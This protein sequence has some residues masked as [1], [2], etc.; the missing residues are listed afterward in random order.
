MISKSQSLSLLSLVDAQQQFV[1]VSEETLL[2]E[3]IAQ[4]SKINHRFVAIDNSTSPKI[5]TPSCSS[6]ILITNN[7]GQL[8][9]IITE[10]DIVRL[11]AEK[12]QLENLTVAQVMTQNIITCKI[13]ELVKPL[14]LIQVMYRNHIRHLPVV[15]ELY[16]PI[17]IVTRG[18]LMGILTQ[19][20]I[21]QAVNVGELQQV[22]QDLQLQVETLQAENVRLLERVNQELKQQVDKQADREKLLLNIA[23]KIRSSLDLQTILQTTVEEVRQHLQ[24]NRVVI[25][26]FEPNW[27]GKVV[28]ESVEQPQWSILNQV[29]RDECFEQTWLT[30]Y[31]EYKSK[32]IAD[33]YQANLSECHIQFLESLHIRANLVIPILVNQKLWGLLIAHHCVEPRLWLTDEI[34]FLEQLGVHLAIA[35][36]QANLLQQAQHTQAELEIEVQ[37]RTNQL[38]QELIERQQAETKVLERQEILRSFYDSSPM[39]MGVVE[40][41]DNDILHLSDNQ[42]TA[43]FFGTTTEALAN[44]KA[45]D[46]GVPEPALQKWLTHY[47]QSQKLGKSVRFEYQHITP[48]KNYWLLAIVSY[49]GIAESGRPRFSYIVE[50]ITDYKQIQAGYNRFSYLLDSSFNEIY[51]FDPETLKFDYVNQGALNNLGYSLEEMQQK[52]AA[53]IKPEITIDQFKEIIYPLVSKQ[54]DKII[55]QSVHR[56]ANGTQYPIEVHLQLSEYLGKQVFLAIIIDITERKEAEAALKESEERYR[57]IVETTQEGIWMLDTD[58]NTSFVNSKMAEMLGYKVEEMLGKSLLTFIEE[59]RHAETLQKLEQRKQGIA[60]QH[61]W[62]FLRKDGTELWALLS[63]NAITNNAGNHIGSLAMVTDISDRQQAE[64]AL[65]IAQ[66]RFSGILDIAN[67]AIIS[68][69]SQQRIILFNQG[70]EKTFG[71]TAEEMIGQPLGKLLPDRFASAHNNHVNSFAGSNGKARRMG[72]RGEIWG[73]RNNGEEFPA[74]ASISKLT[75]GGETIFTTILRDISQRKRDEVALSQLAAIVNSSHD[76]IISKNLDGIITSWNAAA[77]EMFGYTAS[78]IIGCH[79]SQIIP[80]DSRPEADNI[81]ARIREGESVP[82]YETIRQRRDGSLINLALTVSPIRDQKG[83]V[84][85]ASKIARDISERKQAELALKESEERY[86]VLVCH[87]PVGI[88]QTD[89]QGKCLYVNPR[90]MEMTGLSL[91]EALGD[92]WVRSLHP[93]EQLKIFSEWEKTAK[94]KRLFQLEYRFLKPSG[95]EVWVSGQAIAVRDET[96]QVKGYFGTVM[97]ITARK[98]AEEQLRQSQTNLAEAQRIAHLGSWQLDL[99]TGKRTWSDETF[100]IFGLE[101]QSIALTQEVLS[102]L[103]HPDDRWQ[104]QDWIQQVI[105]KKVPVVGE[106]RIIRPDGTMRH[107]ETRAEVILD[108]EG[109]AIKLTGSILDI[110]ERKQAEATKQALFDALPDFM[111]RMRRDGMQLEVLNKDAIHIIKPEENI[112]NIY[113]TD[114]MPLP[115]AQERIAL[116]QQALATNQVQSQEYHFKLNGKTIYEEA[117]IAP[118]GNDEVLVL[119]RDI[120]ERYQAEQA[121]RESEEKFRQLAENIHQ[122]FFILSAEGEMLYISPVYEQVWQRSCE[123]LY[124][125]PRSWLESVHPDDRPVMANALKHQI[126][127]GVSFNETYRI[128]RPDGSIRWVTARS[129]PLRDCTGKVLRFT[130]IAEDVTQQ[131]ESAKAME[132]QLR[133]T[134]LLQHITDQ[135]RQSLDTEQIF[136]VAAQQIGKAFQVNRCLIHF[137]Q[138][139]PVPAIPIV[140]EYLMGNYPSLKHLEIPLAG[141]LHIQKLLTQEKAIASDDVFTDPLLRNLA[142]IC[143]QIGLKSMLAVATFYQGKPNGIIGVHQCVND[144]SSPNNHHRHWQQDEIELIEAVA[145]QLGIAIAQASLLQQEIQRAEELTLK[146]FALEK[147]RKEAERANQA[148]SEF[149]ANMS[150]EIRTPMNA[151]LGFTDL[152]QSVII[153]DRAKEYLDAIASSGKTLLAL[154]NDILDL[155]KIE[156]GKLQIYYEV[157]D[158]HSLIQDIRQIFIQKAK[159][160]GLFLQIHIDEAVPRSLLLDEVRLRQ[161]LFNVVGNALKFTHEGGITIAV[162]QCSSIQTPK[163]HIGLQITISDTGIG[164]SS[165][166]KQRIFEVFTQSQGQSNRK[167]GGTGLGLAITQRLTQMMQGSIELESE[168][169]KGSSLTFC[170]PQVAIAK[171]NITSTSTKELDENLNQFAPARILVVDDVKSNRDLIAGYFT[172]TV[173]HLL[174]AKDGHEAVQIAQSCPLDCIFLDLRMPQMDG[175]EAAYILKKNEQT[176]QIAIIILTASSQKEDERELE[177]ICDGF[178]RKPVSRVQ[179]VTELKKVLGVRA[180]QGESLDQKDSVMLQDSNM[181]SSSSSFLYPVQLS[182]LLVKLRQEA[183]S[184]WEGLRKTLATKDLEQFIERLIQL[185]KEHQCQLLLDYA[186]NLKFQIDEFDWDKIPQTV[187][188]FA[189]ICKS[190]ESNCQELEQGKAND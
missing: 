109:Q 14:L 50:D 68:V 185:S 81:L 115:I 123:S 13:T 33:I 15:N 167:Y 126:G 165:E 151:V 107:L 141:N 99:R 100:R 94:E 8:I 54:K 59:A 30:P 61:D 84:V 175:R 96:D 168:L 78:E 138:T 173:H 105:L 75:L 9:G 76:A 55:F 37:E 164:I 35:I 38:Q 110:T 117:R 180:S 104:I 90:W 170:F 118:L 163:E 184:T 5:E 190:L 27:S 108:K 161:I 143:E 39:M 98:Q 87:A 157:V 17:A 183:K 102:Q 25:Y 63:T 101:P 106:Y 57:R 49:I 111:V 171:D 162:K 71:Y 148:K 56:R 122:V 66:A 10:R 34:Q 125:D 187:E 31:Q 28:V 181:N 132:R 150:H 47:Q 137:Y 74:E 29:V 24:T 91:S 58:G 186:E 20:S 3:A 124:K 44:Q 152:L 131:K 40:L 86:R 64:N 179:I 67:D 139:D 156:A 23:L 46:M 129:F 43:S 119:V 95:E 177:G 73:R 140:S 41:L 189:I 178:L 36:Q 114:I 130:G 32:A 97:D 166:D 188:D 88:F 19:T 112:P 60:E 82:T 169:G 11:I 127:D 22:I 80:I 147:A 53:D 2:L 120:T 133:K 134:L 116:A 72:E 45:R 18:E 160:K 69:D 79:I 51:I 121:L 83:C 135:I 70:A 16:H 172:G 92:G 144:N 154:I 159:E 48:E 145:A 6:C 26:Q 12:R 103:I 158:I 89:A 146:N 182:D 174:F 52:T 128:I 7:N 4:L 77:E 21:L 1:K 85:G 136:E 65:K 149:L 142:P 62:C 153:D 176:R 113:V 42:F 93:D 155:S